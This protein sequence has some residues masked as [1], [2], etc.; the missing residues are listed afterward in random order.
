MASI[1]LLDGGLGQ[2]IQKKTGAS[3]H[4]LWSVK[5]MMEQP[6]IVSDVHREFIAAGADAIAVNTYTATPQRLAANGHPD[7]FEP[8][9]KMALDLAAQ[10][11][12][13]AGRVVHICGCLPPLVA[14]YRADKSL[15]YT[16]SLE[17][18]RSIVAIEKDRVDVFFIETMAKISEAEAAIDAAKESGKPVFVGF[19]VEDDDGNLLRSGENLADAVAMV[20]S[21]DIAG[22]MVNC[23]YPEAVTRAMP[24]LADAGI[25]FGGYANGFTSIAA[26]DPGTTVDR[27]QARTDLTPEI[28][29]DFVF[30]WIEAGATIVGGC[31]EVGPGHIRHLHERLEAGG[32]TRCPL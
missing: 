12:D 31:C 11:R 20:R 21:R 17:S 15:D 30:S 28:Y 4:P 2:E 3:A 7:W 5:V 16:A 26:L 22:V 6:S 1:T 13:A 29:G 9:Q 24:V 8:A 32:Y 23:S 27:L 25:R 19:T 18:F 10:A 14:S